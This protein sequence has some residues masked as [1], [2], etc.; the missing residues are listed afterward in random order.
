MPLPLFP[1]AQVSGLLGEGRSLRAER[2]RLSETSSELRNKVES[3]EGRARE[4]EVECQ[5]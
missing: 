2:D 3:A 4:L 5:R 1:Q